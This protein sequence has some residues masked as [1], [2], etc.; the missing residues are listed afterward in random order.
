MSAATVTS[1]S[2][3]E[4][5]MIRRADNNEWQIPGGVVE[6]G[7]QPTEAAIRETLEETGILVSIGSC[8]GVYTHTERGIFAFVFSAQPID[9]SLA[10]SMESS[11]VAWMPPSEALEKV[12]D[13]FRPRISDAL[14]SEPTALFRA[15]NG[16]EIIR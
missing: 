9:G 2:Q 16:I 1:N 14:S 13:V 8:T 12:S 11:E 15:H 6:P 5:L 3:G 7:E 4:V 10:P